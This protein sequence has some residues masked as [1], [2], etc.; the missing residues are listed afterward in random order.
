MSCKAWCFSTSW[1][2]GGTSELLL[3]MVVMVVFRSGCHRPR[4]PWSAG[5]LCAF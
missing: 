5:L 3:L 1:S 4:C 2:G